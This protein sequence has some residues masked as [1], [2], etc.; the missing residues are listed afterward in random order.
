MV[1]HPL[2]A[3]VE[4]EIVLIFLDTCSIVLYIWEKKGN[5]MKKFKVIEYSKEKRFFVVEAKDKKE[6]EEFVLGC[7]PNPDKVEY[8]DT[9]F[10]IKEIKE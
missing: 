10:E 2:R 6:A 3:G 4:A 9:Y 5:R 1:A 8:S 7:D